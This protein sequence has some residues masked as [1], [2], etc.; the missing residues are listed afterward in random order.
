MYL[1]SGWL[2][3]LPNTLNIAKQSKNKHT[4]WNQLCLYTWK[5]QVVKEQSVQTGSPGSDSHWRVSRV[6]GL[7][8]VSTPPHLSRLHMMGEGWVGWCGWREEAHTTSAV[9]V[10]EWGGEQVEVG[11]EEKGS[12]Q[13]GWALLDHTEPCGRNWN[14]PEHSQ[15]ERRGACGAAGAPSTVIPRSKAQPRP[16]TAQ[17]NRAQ[18]PSKHGAELRSHSRQ[19]IDS[20]KMASWEGH[21]PNQ[22]SFCRYFQWA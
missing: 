10:E 1:E 7:R 11:R 17:L 9:E 2:S 5:H 18:S 15:P 21:Q 4:K 8:S 14:I 16:S 20:Q 12:L 19:L 3:D 6:A 22:S 13:A